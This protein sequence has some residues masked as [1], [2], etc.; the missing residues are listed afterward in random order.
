[1][2]NIVVFYVMDTKKFIINYL[3]IKLFSRISS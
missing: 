2:L 3:T 1:M